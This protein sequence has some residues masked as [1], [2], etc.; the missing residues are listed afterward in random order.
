[1]SERPLTVFVV[2][3]DPAARLIVNFELDDPA[4][5]VVEFDHAE[6]CLA[7]MAQGPD[8]LL[9]DVEMP[10]MNGI[11]LCRA[12]R[13]AGHDHAQAIF[14]SAHDDLD[15]RLAAYDAGGNDFMVKPYA[16]EELARKIKLAE[17]ALA[18]K[19]G[20]SSQASFAQ[21]AAFTAMSSM[22]EMGVVLEFMRKSFDRPTPDALAEAVFEALGQYGLQGLLELHD[23]ARRLCFSTQGVCSALEG[24]I[25]GHAR[26]LQRI[27]QFRDR[28]AINYPRFTLL[29]LNLPLDDP[30]RVGR[31]RDH[32]AILAEAGEARLAAMDSEIRQHAQAKGIGV[33]VAELTRALSEVETRQAGNRMHSLEA[34]NAYLEELDK[35]FVH[36]GLSEGQEA[37]M[38]NMARSAMAR[39]AD[40]LGEDKSLGDQLRAIT[41]RLRILVENGN[42]AT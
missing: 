17:R 7:A 37:A 1:M 18:A 12:I 35:A 39:I 11:D 25:L 32:L 24:S 3:D 38:V 34:T 30:D 36:L 31:L 21:Q 13:E 8:V 29:V 6:A 15:T 5:R 16:P 23:G 20:L 41:E 19:D 27:F 22:G 10:G 42:G 9:L 14:I 28:L 40:Q 4:F 33:A 2:D 26:T